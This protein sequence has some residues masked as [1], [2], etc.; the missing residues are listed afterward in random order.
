MADCIHRFSLDLHHP[1]HLPLDLHSSSRGLSTRVPARPSA[2]RLCR[3]PLPEHD[4]TRCDERCR[5]HVKCLGVIRLVT[6]AACSCICSL[7]FFASRDLNLAPS[8]RS[9]AREAEPHYNICFAFR[10]SLTGFCSWPLLCLLTSFDPTLAPHCFT[11]S[12]SF[13]ISPFPTATR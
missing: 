11:Y 4:T 5:H 2:N 3:L 6:G 10:H 9:F 7:L 8:L 12:V 13:S 1:F